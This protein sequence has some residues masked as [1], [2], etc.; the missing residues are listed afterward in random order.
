MTKLGLEQTKN[1][2]KTTP[3]K[4]KRTSTNLKHRALFSKKLGPGPLSSCRV[5]LF[6]RFPPIL[7]SGDL[8]QSYFVANLLFVLTKTV[9][10]SH[11][12]CKFKLKR[13]KKHNFLLKFAKQNAN[14]LKKKERYR[15]SAIAMFQGIEKSKHATS[16]LSKCVHFNSNLSKNE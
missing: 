16:H 12:Y 7:S 2:K 11:V 10:T 4:Q 13:S 14:L 8:R 15:K 3:T 9:F 1:E 5:H 6:M